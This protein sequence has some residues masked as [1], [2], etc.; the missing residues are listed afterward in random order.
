[1]FANLPVTA[2]RTFES[3]RAL[4][5]FK[6]A[7][8][9]LAVTPTAVSHQVKA[10]EQR[11]GVALFE[12]AAR[13]APDREGRQPVRRRAWRAAGY[14]ADAGRAARRRMRAR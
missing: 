10:L 4:R 12:R 2:L 3:A 1:M 14:R 6:L 8:A 9:E 7:A 5:S 11:V 13:R